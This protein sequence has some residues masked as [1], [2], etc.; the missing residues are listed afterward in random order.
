MPTPV[1]VA[2]Y[3]AS[4]TPF[5][6]NADYKQYLPHVT[7]DEMYGMCYSW[8]EALVDKIKNDLINIGCWDSQR[9]G[10]ACAE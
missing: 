8:I 6:Y 2:Y 3:L 4:G 1:M 7:Q 5:H 9:W 10:V